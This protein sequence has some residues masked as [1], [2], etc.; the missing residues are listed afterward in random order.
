VDFSRF[1]S[2]EKSYDE[3]LLEIEKQ[4]KLELLN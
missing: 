1:Y 2:R 3:V 4:F